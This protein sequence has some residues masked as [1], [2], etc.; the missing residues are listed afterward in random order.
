MK[1]GEI[2]INIEFIVVT[3]SFLKILDLLYLEYFKIYEILAGRDNDILFSL[4]LKKIDIYCLNVY[5]KYDINKN[6]VFVVVIQSFLNIMGLLYSKSS[7][8]YEILA[9]R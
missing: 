9:E 4:Y 5:V 3:E 1:N 7:R 6:I 2:Y 8:I